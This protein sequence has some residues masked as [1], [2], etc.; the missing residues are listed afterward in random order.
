M[1]NYELLFSLSLSVN[2]S[3][4][5]YLAFRHFQARKVAHKIRDAVS[6]IK[7]ILDSQREKSEQRQRT[8][9]ELESEL[10]EIIEDSPKVTPLNLH[11]SDGVNFSV[12]ELNALI[13]MLDMSNPAMV[14]LRSKFEI[15]LGRV[16]LKD[17]FRHFREGSWNEPAD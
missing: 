13:D 6:D 15:F 7:E 8:W 1:I 3:L 14:G 10:D 2:I 5:T 9:T 12:E 11:K 4:V 17:K 16:Q